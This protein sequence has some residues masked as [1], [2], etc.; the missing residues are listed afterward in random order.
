MK[1]ISNENE[2]HYIA[3]REMLLMNKDKF[4]KYIYIWRKD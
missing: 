4:K 1:I 3:L 2:I